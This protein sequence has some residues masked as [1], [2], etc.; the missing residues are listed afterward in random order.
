MPVSLSQVLSVVLALAVTYY[1]LGLVVSTITKFITEALDTRGRSLEA[2]LRKNL[3]GE[4]EEGKILLLDKLK[5]MP[6]LNS[7]KPVRYAGY[8]LGFFGWKGGTRISDYVERIPPKNLVDALFDLDGTLKKGNEKVQ[9]VIGRLPDKLPGP[10]GPIEFAA[11]TELKKLADAG[12]DDVEALRSKME[13]WFTGLMDQ[14]AEEFKAQARRVVILLSLLVTLALGVDSIELAQKYWKNA[15]ISTTANAQASLI[16]ASPEDENQKKAD[17]QKLVADLVEMNA[18]NYTWYQKPSGAP[19]NWLFLK[20]AGLLITA[21]AVSQGA[22]FWYDLMKRIK[23]EQATD[24]RDE[25]ADA[26]AA[27]RGASTGIRSP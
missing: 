3:L 16:L 22:S 24:E 12:F 10:N 9:E 5:R 1:I 7:L 4:V 19:G 26:A 20:I 8:G 21:F 25:S 23:G 15:T 27:L 11:R 6:Q 13:T 14:A 18:I 17:I 2:F